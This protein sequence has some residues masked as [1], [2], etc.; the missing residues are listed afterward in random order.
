MT[1]R[2]VTVVQILAI[3]ALL[4]ILFTIVGTAW[5]YQMPA[6]PTVSGEVNL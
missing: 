2:R 4:G 6:S 5:I 1:K 3:L